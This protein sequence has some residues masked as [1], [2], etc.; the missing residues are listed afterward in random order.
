MLAVPSHDAG[1]LAVHVDDAIRTWRRERA[2]AAD[3]ADVDAPTDP[4]LS[5]WVPVAD[6]ACTVVQATE[7]D[8]VGVTLRT[9]GSLLLH[10]A[11]FGDACGP[12]VEVGDPA[13]SP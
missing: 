12:R 6:G 9:D 5:S 3:D 13:P 1:D 10:E 11:P 8:Q 2:A 4:A 7:F